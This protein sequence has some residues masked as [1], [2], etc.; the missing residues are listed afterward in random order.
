MATSHLPHPLN[1]SSS[2]PIF[3]LPTHL[4]PQELHDTEDLIFQS[5]GHLTYDAKEARVFIGRVAQKKRAAFDLRARGVWTEEAALPEVSSNRNEDREPA[6]EEG[7]ERKKAKL[8]D[9]TRNSRPSTRRRRPSSS[10]ISASSDVSQNNAASPPAQVLWPDLSAH[11]L[12]LKL[13]WLEACLKEGH[14]V[15]YRPYVVYTARVIPKPAGEVSP[16]S[17]VSLSAYFKVGSGSQSQTV[18]SRRASK[19]AVSASILDRAKAEAA[20]LPS[21]SRRRYGDHAHHHSLAQTTTTKTKPNLHRTTTSEL[22]YQAEHPLPPLPEWAVGPHAPYACCRSTFM[23]SP[24]DAFIAQLT[25][26][27]DARTLTLDDIGVR[28]Y[29]TSIASIAAYP[30]HITQAEEITRLPG[31]ESK[32]AALWREWEDSAPP[33][34]DDS[35]RFIQVVRDSDADPDLQ[36]LRLFWNIWGVGPETAR[37]FYFEHGWKD[38]DDVVE[39]GWSTL[40]RVQQIGVKYYD[41]FLQKIPRSEV[42]SISNVILRHTRSVLEIPEQKYGTKEDAEL[43]IV[44]GYRRGK[45]FSGDVDVVLSHRDHSKTENLV[46]DVVRSLESEGWVTHT[47]TL[48]TTT[49]DRGQTT[50]P[51]R[52]GHGHGFDSLDKALCVWQDPNYEGKDPEA[53]EDAARKKN[54]NIH[55]RVDI[56][57]SP[58][59][60]VGCAVLGWSGGT[61]F[62]RDVRRFVKKTHGLKFDSSG[63]RHRGNGLVLDLEAPRPRGNKDAV[64]MV[65]MGKTLKRSDFDAGDEWDDQDTWS[66]R[67]RRLMEGLGI[68][69]RPPEER[70][71]G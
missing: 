42:E 48:N 37:K 45:E 41:E 65:L 40:T 67:E 23:H 68:G 26:I 66:D 6:A 17:Q 12:I 57:V 18:T 55:R 53:D 47:L 15:P 43:I 64:E 28:A 35:E 27:R 60:T 19:P 14:L 51:F 20:T 7:P 62:Q 69:Y 30:Y 56:I 39:F 38:M 70:C 16:K 22:E 36:H 5:G 63:V 11:I 61:T 52:T 1:L 9:H 21:S 46:V 54:P 33:E 49:S 34:A 59:R 29:S 25:K 71:T 32:I 58:W 24:N 31:C 8:A 13:S 50:L 3:I 4:K 2:P 44:G 10:T